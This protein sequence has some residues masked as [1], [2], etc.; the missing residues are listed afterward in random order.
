MKF[1]D[2]LKFTS[3]IEQNPSLVLEAYSEPGFKRRISQ[4]LKNNLPE[5]SRIREF[6]TDEKIEQV[7][8]E[9][10]AML[11]SLNA[12]GKLPEDLQIEKLGRMYQTL[13]LKGSK[14]F[15]EKVAQKLRECNIA[16]NANALSYIE[17]FIAENENNYGKFELPRSLIKNS[18][19]QGKAELAD[20]SERADTTEG[21]M[22]LRD[23]EIERLEQKISAEREKITAN[24]KERGVPE[25]RIQGI[26]ENQLGKLKRNLEKYN[27]RE[28]ESE[29]AYLRR[30]SNILESP[31]LS[32]II[33][34]Q[35]KKEGVYY[36]LAN[37]FLIYL[38]KGINSIPPDMHLPIFRCLTMTEENGNVADVSSDKV[39]ELFSFNVYN[40]PY[41]VYYKVNVESGEIP[42]T[43]IEEIISR[44]ASDLPRL[45]QYLDAGPVER[46]T[47][48]ADVIR[49]ILKKI[50]N[51]YLYYNRTLQT[52]FDLIAERGIVTD[53]IPSIKDFLLK[54]SR[55]IQMTEGP[56]WTKEII[57]N[58]IV[59]YLT[60][61]NFKLG[62]EMDLFSVSPIEDIATEIYKLLSV[63]LGNDVNIKRKERFDELY[64]N[65]PAALSSEPAVVVNTDQLLILRALTEEQSVNAR[66]DYIE[67]ITREG[68][69][70]TGSQGKMGR[71]RFGWC[72]SSSEGCHYD[73]YR[74]QYKYT[75][76]FIIVKPQYY[77]AKKLQENQGPENET[78]EQLEERKL[79]YKEEYCNNKTS[80]TVAQ[81][82]QDGY[83]LFTGINNDGDRTVSWEDI[84]SEIP[85]LNSNYNG[86]SI[87]SLLDYI[88]P[89]DKRVSKIY[90][91]QNSY[92]KLPFVIKNHSVL[93]KRWMKA[94]PNKR[95]LTVNEF[96]E[97]KD[98][99]TKKTYMDMRPH[100]SKYNGEFFKD[101][102]DSIY[103][104]LDSS[105]D[106]TMSRRVL[107]ETNNGKYL[108]LISNRFNNYPRNS[109]LKL[110]Q[111]SND[112]VEESDDGTPV[113][114]F[115]PN[116]TIYENLPQ[117][118]AY[119][120]GKYDRDTKNF[121]FTYID[122]EG[123]ERPIQELSIYTP[124]EEELAVSLTER[125]LYDAE[126]MQ[127]IYN[128]ADLIK[129]INTGKL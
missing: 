48:L 29:E 105:T 43:K 114:S 126:I 13:R 67:P 21:V 77:I 94:H 38:S 113:T 54:A 34:N 84:V 89:S 103:S 31:Q 85:E 81:K 73:M 127:D 5:D 3:K 129:L 96:T 12:A 33:Q 87:D 111:K 125:T 100:L 45:K 59:D 66:K 47:T 90:D 72:V 95:F 102:N 1:N 39:S 68:A 2:L 128:A 26:V 70:C 61:N 44:L 107:T 106:A 9:Y 20:D 27:R 56:G 55:Y 104:S 42:R 24:L 92:Y 30:L 10:T 76:Y 22:S 63:T 71:F 62:K 14:A 40:M 82:K 120:I 115:V 101:E 4:L 75:Q 60:E 78:P 64:K 98:D 57:I 51:D 124:T 36:P 69:G 19:E 80:V 32:T 88:P 50:V 23:E 11:D 25:N 15:I 28:D 83:F 110:K 91:E 37:D 41:E 117:S 8:D 86:K 6:Y 97:L 53:Y 65:Y 58:K 109:I 116:N 99:D 49:A 35:I 17:Q 16:L 52:D 118:R 119:V 108:A 74:N 121:I 18:T 7:V 112:F 46:Y 93:L 79:R 122:E 123:N